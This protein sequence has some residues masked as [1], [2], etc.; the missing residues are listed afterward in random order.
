MGSTGLPG[1]GAA[2]WGV[3]ATLERP[4]GGRCRH[5]WEHTADRQPAISI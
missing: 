4:R 5:R 1:A 3:L 2:V